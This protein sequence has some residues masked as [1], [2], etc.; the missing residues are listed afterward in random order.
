LRIIPPLPDDELGKA[1]SGRRW[2]PHWAAKI[3]EENGR[4]LA[5][6]FLSAARNGDWR[7]AQALM[8]RIYGKPVEAT[9]TL[10]PPSPIPS[11][12]A[13]MTLEEKLQLLRS[14]QRGAG[15]AGRH[16]G[17]SHSAATLG[18]ELEP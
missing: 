9:V 11:V 14:L 3:V 5:E 17:S 8:D 10:A 13:S 12:L 1:G 6:S 2:D 4:D 15:R 7:A 16:P 18:N